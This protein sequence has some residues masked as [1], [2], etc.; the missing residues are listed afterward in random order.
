[1]KECRFLSCRD[2]RQT[3]ALSASAEVVLLSDDPCLSLR[4]GDEVFWDFEGGTTTSKALKLGK[5][6][7][8]TQALRGKAF[9]VHLTHIPVVSERATFFVMRQD[10]QSSGIQAAVA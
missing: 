9:L 4:E 8:E 1:M 2:P 6:V 5:V 3:R 7:A 10:D